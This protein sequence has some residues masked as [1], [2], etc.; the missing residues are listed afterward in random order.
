M[1]AYDKVSHFSP[2]LTHVHSYRSKI[3]PHPLCHGGASFMSAMGSVLIDVRARGSWACTSVFT[4]LH[5]TEESQ[6]LKDLK[7]SSKLY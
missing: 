7:I 4:Y 2:N 5:H 1:L 3:C 6:L